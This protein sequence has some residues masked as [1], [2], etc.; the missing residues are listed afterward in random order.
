MIVG[1]PR[2][3][4][5]V[6]MVATTILISIPVIPVYT[7]GLGVA[8]VFYKQF[9]I[10]SIEIGHVGW[11]WQIGGTGIYVYG[12]TEGRDDLHIP[13][14]QQNGFWEVQ[15]NY[16]SMMNAFK[17]KNYINYNCEKVENIDINA[18][19]TKVVETKVS[20]YDVIGNNCL[21]HTI[22]IL[23]AYNAK[24]FPTEFL[25]KDWFNELSIE[26][27]NNGGNWLPKSTTL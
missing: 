21:D 10:L 2:F 7:L 15:G 24:G 27:N 6:I 17:A 4:V 20:G 5:S 1:H 22:A 11:S 18:A 3:R 8:C 26:G 13:K 19:Y 14:G 9:S 23:I 12:S 16:E 25:P